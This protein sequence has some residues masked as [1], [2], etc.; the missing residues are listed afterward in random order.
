MIVGKPKSINLNLDAV[1]EESL[2][3]VGFSF[4]FPDTWIV[5]C[6]TLAFIHR[7]GTMLVMCDR[8]SDGHF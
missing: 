1:I 2:R 4:K 8:M 3:S 5:D 7:R 6:S